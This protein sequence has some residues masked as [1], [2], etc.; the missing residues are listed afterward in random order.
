MAWAVGVL[1]YDSTR[2]TL[3][4]ERELDTRTPPGELGYVT[5]EDTS[6]QKVDGTCMSKSAQVEQA[7]VAEAGSIKWRTKEMLIGH[8]L[9]TSHALTA[10]DC[11]CRHTLTIDDR[12][13][14]GVSG[15]GM[16]SGNCALTTRIEVMLSG[17]GMPTVR[18]DLS[19][20]GIGVELTL[21][22]CEAIKHN[23]TLRELCLNKNEIGNT[24]AKHIAQLLA[25][26]N[27]CR[28]CAFPGLHLKLAEVD[29]GN[30]NIGDTGATH[31]AQALEKNDR[32]RELDLDGNPIRPPGLKALLDV[33]QRNRFCKVVMP[34]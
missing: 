12:I 34:M 16:R 28:Q 7:H 3:D 25:E 6:F 31:L 21:R 26:S 2:H 5:F 19:N 20:S 4:L 15:N 22:L 14:R 24:G 29:L 10:I 1:S 11:Q 17:F 27:P 32:L 8:A 13:A 33:L 30:N 18:L 23:R 9:V